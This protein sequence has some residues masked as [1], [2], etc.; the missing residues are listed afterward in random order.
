MYLI[1]MIEFMVDGM[2]R[3][4]KAFRESLAEIGSRIKMIDIKEGRKNGD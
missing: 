1:K 2:I 3:M 4:E